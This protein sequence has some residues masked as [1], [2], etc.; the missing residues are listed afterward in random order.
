MYTEEQKRQVLA[1][2]QDGYSLRE[3]EEHTGIGKSTAS[4]W[5]NDK[6]E[7]SKLK[8]WDAEELSQNELSQAG[9]EGQDSRRDNRPKTK[10]RDGAIE[11]HTY[12]KEVEL[13]RLELEHERAMEKL[14]QQRK[15]LELE[16]QKL[17]NEEYALQIKEQQLQQQN[18][19]QLHAALQEAK[20]K[21]QTKRKLLQQVKKQA[22]Y[23]QEN[24]KSQSWEKSELE[25]LQEQFLHLKEKVETVACELEQDYEN[26]QVWQNLEIIIEAIEEALDQIKRSFFKDSIELDWD[27]QEEAALQT[28][29]DLY[30]LD[31]P[32]DNVDDNDNN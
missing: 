32:L 9:E 1:L 25:D 5:I 14:Y 30:A 20:Q 17:R 24:R 29:I 26:W 11:N 21:D 19:N 31:Q 8:V 2:Y 23:V 10:S 22:L 16:E 27:Q 15:A 4:R 13:R 3:I 28:L 6:E 18:Q 12:D 7:E